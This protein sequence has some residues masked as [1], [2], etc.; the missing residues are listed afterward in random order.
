MTDETITIEMAC[1]HCGKG[2]P[3]V[4]P[5]DAA[6]SVAVEVMLRVHVPGLDCDEKD[7]ESVGDP[8]A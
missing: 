7:V 3:V 6:V 1:G 2:V 5:R 4:C 8:R